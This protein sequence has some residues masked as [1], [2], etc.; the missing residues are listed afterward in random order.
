MARCDFFKQWLLSSLPFILCIIGEYLVV[1]ALAVAIIISSGIMVK[2]IDDQQAT[3]ECWPAVLLSGSGLFL[4]RFWTVHNYQFGRTRTILGT[5]SRRMRFAAVIL[6]IFVVASG[7]MSIWA[8]IGDMVMTYMNDHANPKPTLDQLEQQEKDVPCLFRCYGGYHTSIVL[9]TMLAAGFCLLAIGLEMEDRAVD[10]EE[11]ALIGSTASA[12]TPDST[13]DLT[14]I[15][16]P[17]PPPYN[18]D[19]VPPPSYTNIINIYTGNNGSGSEAPPPSYEVAVGETS[20]PEEPQQDSS[21][22]Q[23]DSSEPQPETRIIITM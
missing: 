18:G 16:P 11:D 20:Q 23:P 1:G 8:S 17:L 13:V 5:R 9:Y 3:G 7:V 14:A 2:D 4:T 12:F 6:A 21:E 22:P 15:P 10:A 19:G